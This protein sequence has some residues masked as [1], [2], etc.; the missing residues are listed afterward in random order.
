MIHLV[1]AREKVL[2]VVQEVGDSDWEVRKSGW[3]N[4]LGPAGLQRPIDPE[5]PTDMLGNQSIPSK[6]CKD[7]P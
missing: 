2:Q 7:L 1:N 3:Y 6:V 5:V 4:S